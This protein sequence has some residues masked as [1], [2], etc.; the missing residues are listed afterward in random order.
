MRNKVCDISPVRNGINKLKIVILNLEELT[1]VERLYCIFNLVYGKSSSALSYRFMQKE[2]DI[3]SNK[4]SKLFKK[5][6]D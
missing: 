6:V 2:I 1:D 4:N 3:V 5:K